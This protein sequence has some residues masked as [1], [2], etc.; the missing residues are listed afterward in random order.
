MPTTCPHG[1]VTP[2]HCMWCLAEH[3][4]EERTVLRQIASPR[5][6]TC[7]QPKRWELRSCL[8][9]HAAVDCLCCDCETHAVLNPDDLEDDD[10]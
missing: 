6:P 3:L 10:N 4:E 2:R 5:C 8:V 9:C 1:Y 7:Q